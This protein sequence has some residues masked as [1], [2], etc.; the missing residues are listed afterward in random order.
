MG[1]RDNESVIKPVSPVTE[2]RSAVFYH[3]MVYTSL[4][5]MGKVK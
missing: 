1:G 3:D 5:L 4:F 2:L